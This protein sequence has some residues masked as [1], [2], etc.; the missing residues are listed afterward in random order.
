MCCIR[1]KLIPMCMFTYY[2]FVRKGEF[3][4]ICLCSSVYSWFHF[5]KVMGSA[6]DALIRLRTEYWKKCNDSLATQFPTQTGEWSKIHSNIILKNF[7][8]FNYS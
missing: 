2:V 4:C 1:I 6:L 8:L 7:Q 3:M 5:L